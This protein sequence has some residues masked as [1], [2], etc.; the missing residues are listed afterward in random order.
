MACFVRRLSARTALFRSRGHLSDSTACTTTEQADASIA[1]LRLQA[2][3]G[4][5]AARWPVGFFEAVAPV[6]AQPWRGH[7]NSPC[8]GPAD[9]HSFDLPGEGHPGARGIWAGLRD[10]FD[11]TPGGTGN[12]GPALLCGIEGQTGQFAGRRT[13]V[14]TTVTPGERSQGSRQ[15][16]TPNLVTIE[17]GRPRDRSSPGPPSRPRFRSRP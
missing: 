2:Y 1:P 7:V 11:Q 14:A 6:P 12:Q 4:A 17:R 15:S 3:Q 10:G 16:L 13:W 9:V 8:R 5:P